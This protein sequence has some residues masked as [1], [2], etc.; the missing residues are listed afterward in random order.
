MIN[1]A[2]KMAEI[3]GDTRRGWKSSPLNFYEKGWRTV[4]TGPPDYGWFLNRQAS[5][6]A[7]TPAKFLSPENFQELE[8][9][10][11]I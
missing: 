3:I 10:L 9:R 4:L 5:P 6:L 8:R 2:E 1:G 11:G 7:K